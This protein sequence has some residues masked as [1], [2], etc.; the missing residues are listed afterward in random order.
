MGNTHD[1]IME[2]AVIYNLYYTILYYMCVL[3]HITEQTAEEVGL[4]SCQDEAER[5]ARRLL[6]GK[7][8]GLNKLRRT[9]F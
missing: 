6:L 7:G 9:E 8:A 4:K 2:K 1:E 3:C 5:A